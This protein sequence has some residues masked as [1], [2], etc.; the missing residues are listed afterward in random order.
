MAILAGCSN[1][2][3]EKKTV[4]SVEL[5]KQ[6]YKSLAFSMLKSGD[7]EKAD[8]LTDFQPDSID[9]FYT[10]M[11]A[12]ADFGVDSLA[13]ARKK[14]E[15]YNSIDTS[16]CAEVIARKFID[17]IDDR[18]AD[19]GFRRSY[20]VVFMDEIELEHLEK[21]CSLLSDST[22]NTYNVKIE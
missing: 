5:S 13:Q 15:D 11:Q 9:Q 2:A 7:Y 21:V 16:Q 4:T 1:S 6:E 22:Q 12:L 14:F 17:L 8:S 18:S 19:A 10:L 3:E 20:L